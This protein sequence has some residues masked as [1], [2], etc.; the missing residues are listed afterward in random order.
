MMPENFMICDIESTHKIISCAEILTIAFIKTDL[1]LNV[2]EKRSWKMR[3]KY[4]AEEHNAASIEAHRITREEAMQFPDKK[5][6]LREIFHWFN[7]QTYIFAGH[8]NRDNYGMTSSYDYALLKQEFFDQSPEAYFR[9]CTMF[10]RQYI[11]STHSIADKA[12]KA[13]LINVPLVVKE[14]NK[15]AS[16]DFGLKNICRIMGIHIDE[17]KHHGAEYDADVTLELLKRFKNRMNIFDVIKTD[18]RNEDE[19]SNF[20]GETGQRSGIELHEF[21]NCSDQVLVSNIEDL[22][23]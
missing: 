16:R 7:K 23:R 5:Q 17:T 21:W 15:K 1:D 8:F 12:F 22:D 20:T 14:G 4:W 18:W 2:I 10:P 13:S 6:V 3:P 19:Q 11:C 9:F